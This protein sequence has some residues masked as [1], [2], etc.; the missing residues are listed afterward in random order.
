[1]IDTNIII[2]LLT[3]SEK[4]D[5]AKAIFKLL[6]DEELVITLNVLE[7]VVY[8]GFSAIYGCRGFKL[9]DKVRK[10]L[11][12]ECEAFLDGLSSFME[13]FHIRMIPP[14]NDPILFLNIIRTYRLLPADA[15]IAASCKHHGIDKIATLDADFKRVDFLKVIEA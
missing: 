3:N 7:E 2:S 10:G 14:S 1:L 6:N 11:N 12:D 4:V 13:V 5:S 9:R 8:V 15:A